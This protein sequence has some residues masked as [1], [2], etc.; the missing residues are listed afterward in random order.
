MSYLLLASIGLAILVTWLRGGKLSQL[1]DLHFWFWW[2]VPL[3]AVAQSMLVRSSYAGMRLPW[4]ETRPMGMVLSYIVLGVVV[5]LNRQF[6][7]MW[8]VLGG[9]ALNAIAM[10]ANGGYMP[11]TPWALA[12]IGYGERVEQLPIG[13]VVLGSKDVM[14]PPG[15]GYLWFLGD[16][17]VIPEPCPRPTAMS[18]GDILLAVGV[19]LF[20]LQTTRS[21]ATRQKKL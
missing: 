9:T 5:L 21:S 11:I 7:G 19:F 8:A 16:T 10:A 1:A 12:L 18:I 15:Q 17:L 13:T 14:L 4:W 2:A 6:P 3:T 20:I